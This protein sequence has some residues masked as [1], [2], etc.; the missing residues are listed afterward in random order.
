MIGYLEFKIPP[1][2]YS[3]CSS[4]FSFLGRGLLYVLIGIL[5]FH[6]SALRI[7]V[8]LLVAAIGIVYCVLEFVQG[9]QPPEN[10]QGEQ[11]ISTD[12]L[13]DVI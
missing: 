13:D 7:L 1:K 12:G 6:G 10:M 4:F 2:L 3:Y 8:S 5:N 11:G 9:V